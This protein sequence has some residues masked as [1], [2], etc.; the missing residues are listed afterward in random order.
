MDV[1]GG[2]AESPRAP[3]A[4]GKPDLCLGKEQAMN[5]VNDQVAPAPA[6][7][8]SRG[9]LL[10]CVA[11][12]AVLAIGIW[13]SGTLSHAAAPAETGRE[14]RFNAS[15]QRMKTLEAINTTNRKLDKLISLLESGKVRV[16]VIELKEAKAKG[17]V[18]TTPKK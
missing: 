7:V 18:K 2:A 10:A 6:G 16:S 17:D 3:A 9:L 14:L 4:T 11:L 12:L 15:T 8:R 5:Q 13:A 1:G